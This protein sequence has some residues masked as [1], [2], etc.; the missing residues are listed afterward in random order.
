MEKTSFQDK[1]LGNPAPFL[2]CGFVGYVISRL[3]LKPPSSLK[4]TLITVASA[5]IGAAI[6]IKLTDSDKGN[7]GMEVKS[8]EPVIGHKETNN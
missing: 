8:D 2:I 1:V 3:E 5:F 7:V 4:S 6:Y